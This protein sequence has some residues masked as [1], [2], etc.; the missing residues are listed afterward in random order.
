MNPD[1]EKQLEAAIDRELKGL[2]ELSAP[3]TLASRIMRTLEQRAALP[4]YRRAWQT[5]PMA[6][7]AA[8]LTAMLV[9]F[10]GVCFGVVELFQAASA[11]APAHQVGGWLASVGAVFKTVAVLAEAVVLAVRQLGVTLLIGCIVGIAMAYAAC[12]GLGTAWMRLAL[13]KR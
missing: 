3:A 10:G 8:S 2:G 7:Q 1:Y 9:V 5:W 11:T 4:W 13:A 12:I 6:W